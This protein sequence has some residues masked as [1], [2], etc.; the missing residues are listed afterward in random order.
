MPLDQ[1][2]FPK[3][4]TLYLE[5]S[6]YPILAPRVRERMRQELFKRGVISPEAFEA[7]V[8]EKSLQSQEREGLDD[9]FSQEPQDV[10]INRLAIVRDHLTDF[11]FAYNFPH[12]RF[13]ELLRQTLSK[14]IP[15]EDVILSIHPELAPWDM[16]FAQGEA[17]EA[18]PPKQRR[19]AEHHLKEIKV[20]LIKAMISDHLDYVGIAKDWFDITDLQAI[21]ARR[22]GR[23]K[24]GG[25]AAGVM[26]AECILRKSADDELL[27]KL[28]IPQSWFLGADVFYQFT[29]MN[30]LF[31]YMNQKYKNE[32]V[33]RSEYPQIREEFGTGRFPKEIAEGLRVILDDA[34]S[35]PLIVRSSSLLEDSFGT[36]FAGKY[37]SVFCPNQ[38]TPDENLSDLQA[39]IRKVYASVY[40]P[41]VLLY[42]RQKGLT[43]YDERMAVLIQELQGRRSGRYFMP[44]AAGV[45]L[46]R[47]Q[48]RW[49]PRIDRRAGVL[50]I[51]WGL[52]TRAVEQLGED[53]PRLVA[54]SHP[55]LRPNTDPK[56]ILRYSQR[57]VDLID[58]ETN[59]FRTL[60]TTDVVGIHTPYLR[61]LAQRYNAGQMEDFV[62][63]PL[64]FSP[65]DVVITFEGLMRRTAFPAQMRKMLMRLETAYKG[66]VDTEFTLQIEHSESGEFTPIISLLQ[67]R[68]Q[69]HL[70]ADAVKLP[71][72][73]PPSQRLFV[74]QRLVPD[75]QVSD[76]R[77]AV[78]VV[79]KGYAN[80]SKVSEKRE[81]ARLIGRLNK[82]L[83]D[84]VFILLGPGRWGSNNPE[85]G[86]P[87]TY[88]EIHN[89]RA[90]IEV[91]D[92]KTAP[93]PSFGTHFFQDMVE[94]QIFPLAVAL[95]DPGAEFNRS[96]FEES[97]NALTGLLPDDRAWEKIVRVI[98]V[99]TVAEGAQLELMMDGEAGKAMAYLQ[100][101]LEDEDTLTADSSS[102]S[103]Y[104]P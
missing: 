98:D 13:E 35:N 93:E 59:S 27:K 25:K 76:V 32:E 91:A 15:T 44:D 30:S 1:S 12:E 99:N 46:S 22:Y 81:V 31:I 36:S 6:Q 49:S 87:V 26:L 52:G 8:R 92:D 89:A 74:T 23:G 45:A 100:L 65:A 40:S 82:K 84:Q 14:R 103:L 9:P 61:L 68:P 77:Y 21:R 48:F 95:E 10:W 70:R 41:D 64:G 29:Q 101:D 72:D 17:Y 3:V 56:S 97:A 60:P 2:E 39:A 78:Y 16:L 20:V 66:P 33:I 43:D 19:K 96:F 57:Y 88:S 18:M 4:L 73:I 80:L 50:R 38:G 58:L 51:V 5:L 90:L 71:E 11:Y 54:L 47:N 53:Y 79:P 86:I 34:G 24:I 69:S 42:R 75:G 104:P 67:C 63:I 37:E 55:D 85:L 83:E 28:R 7:E 62:S 94:A 102:N